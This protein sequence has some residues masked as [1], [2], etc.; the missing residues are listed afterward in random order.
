M[1]RTK[2]SGER[3][4]GHKVQIVRCISACPTDVDRCQI[5]CT[6]RRSGVSLL[7]GNCWRQ[8]L[9][10]SGSNPYA[11]ANEARCQ[12]NNKQRES[13]SAPEQGPPHCGV[14]YSSDRGKHSNPSFFNR[15]VS[16]SK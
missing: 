6:H 1:C 16:L 12:Q 5:Q 11:P 8:S 14:L 13:S 10:R 7:A 3:V 4:V 15:K 9:S 2:T